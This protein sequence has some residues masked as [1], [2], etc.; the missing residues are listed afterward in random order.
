MASHT[1]GA[2]VFTP[3]SGLQ[4]IVPLGP[5]THIRFNNFP[6]GSV[7]DLRLSGKVTRD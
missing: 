3:P 2:P 6:D 1:P 5:I 4:Q 7:T